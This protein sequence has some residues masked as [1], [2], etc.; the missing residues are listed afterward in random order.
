MLKEDRSAWK[1]K[2][3]VRLM[4]YFDEY[5]KMFVVTAD[6]VGSRQMQKLR[7]SLRGHA[8][9]IMGKNSIMRKAIRQQISKNTNLERLLPHVYQNVGFIFTKGDLR[10]VQ[11]KIFENTVAAPARVGTF[12]P[13]DVTI[14]TQPTKL[15]P[16]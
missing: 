2:Y 11:G 6:N 3:I 12:A 4:E 7:V 14:R 13:V 10:L 16:E 8:T 9:I 1:G 5:P 15:G